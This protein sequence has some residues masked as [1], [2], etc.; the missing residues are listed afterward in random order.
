MCSRKGQGMTRY[1]AI[2][3][4][5]LSTG[6]LPIVILLSGKTTF[7][8][9]ATGWS[10]SALGVFHRWIS[11]GCVFLAVIHSACFAIIKADCEFF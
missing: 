5:Y 4:G 6:L 9:R 3:T 1:L 7:L 10:G 8:Q 2:R 11:R